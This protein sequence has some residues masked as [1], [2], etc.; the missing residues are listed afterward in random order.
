MSSSAFYER[1]RAGQIPRAEYPFSPSK[2]YWRMDAI[3]KHEQPA[4]QAAAATA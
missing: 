2:P 3:L 4:A 1:L